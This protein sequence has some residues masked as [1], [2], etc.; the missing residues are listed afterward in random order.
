MPRYFLEVAYKGTNYSG[1]QIQKNANSIQSE[2][3]RALQVFFKYPVGLTG[4]SRTDAGVHAVQNYFHFDLHE[5]GTVLPAGKAADVAYRLNAI[6]PWDITISNLLAVQDT[7]HCRYD[8][9]EREYKY[10][11]YS[12]KN[13][14][15]KDNA[16]FFPYRLQPE[17]LKAGAGI[18]AGQ[19]NFTSF[20]KRSTQVKNYI[21]RINTSH[22][23]K[24]G[25]RLVYTVSADRFLRGMVRGLVAT[26]LR[27]GRGIINEED[28]KNIFAANDCRKADFSVPAHGLFLNRIRYRANIFS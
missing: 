26:M 4:A 8:A 25:D 16:Y 28:L 3:E 17:L 15:L 24:D 18:I 9:V 21:C 23:V 22:W 10:Y 20:C 27:M 7:A 12:K 11:I 14:F 13:P 5:P 6:L 2:I 19:Y 1:F